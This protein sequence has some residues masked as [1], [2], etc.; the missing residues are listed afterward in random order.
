[1][2]VYVGRRHLLG[3]TPLE[4][5]KKQL[6]FASELLLLLSQRNPSPDHL[7]R[8][9][10]QSDHH[11]G[12]PYVP[13]SCHLLPLLPYMCQ[14]PKEQH[15]YAPFTCSLSRSR[16]VSFPSRSSVLQQRPVL[17]PLVALLCQPM[18]LL[19]QRMNC[20]LRLPLHLAQP[21][22]R[23][24]LGPLSYLLSHGFYPCLHM[25]PSCR[26]CRPSRP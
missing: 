18:Y 25:Q 2:L 17:V 6:I 13:V 23:P 9:L 4:F 8:L 26:L 19:L 5:I 21:G 11:V 12:Q 22:P 24:R 10:I 14:P 20:C 15:F 7:L 3:V 1:M 16:P